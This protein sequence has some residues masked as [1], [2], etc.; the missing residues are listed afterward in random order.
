MKM[1]PCSVN[2]NEKSIT[3]WC[4]NQ[5]FVIN[6]IP[7]K[8]KSKSKKK[9]EDYIPL[10]SESESEGIELVGK[11]SLYDRRRKRIDKEIQ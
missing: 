11:P 9:V 2:N 8:T 1:N 5:P 3:T 10:S 6:S 7:A 4:I